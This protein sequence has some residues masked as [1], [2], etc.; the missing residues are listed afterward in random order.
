MFCQ[1]DLASEEC[2]GLSEGTLMAFKAL[3]AMTGWVIFILSRFGEGPK[4]TRWRLTL[5]ETGYWVSNGCQ[6]T[7]R[8]T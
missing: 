2:G 1:S 4:A 6:G 8:M 3:Q 5:S 7:S